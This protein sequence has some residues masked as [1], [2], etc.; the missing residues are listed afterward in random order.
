[1][2]VHIDNSCNSIFLL[3]N[4]FSSKSLWA[5]S[6]GRHQSMWSVQNEIHCRHIQTLTSSP[7]TKYYNEDLLSLEMNS[8]KN[9]FFFENLKLHLIVPLTVSGTCG[10]IWVRSNEAMSLF[11]NPI[12]IRSSF[13]LISIVTAPLPL[14]LVQLLTNAI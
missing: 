6:G 5:V 13:L 8:N 9:H 4:P 10:M 11:L 12:A 14:S 1:M 3:S 7:C 2:Q